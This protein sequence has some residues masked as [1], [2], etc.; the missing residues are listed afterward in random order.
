VLNI[1]WKEAIHIIV[2][3]LN[4]ELLRSNNDKTPYELWACRPATVNY[5]KIFGSKCYIKINE[6]NLGKFHSIIDEGIL[7]GYPS[8]RKAYRCYNVR[9]DKIVMSANV[10]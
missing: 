3:I 2:Y 6:E 9:L 1:F 7:L 10:K 8:K 4:R 5:F